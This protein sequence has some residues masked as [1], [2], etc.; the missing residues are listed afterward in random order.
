[1]TT[2]FRAGSLT[3]V[4]GERAAVAANL[5]E[6]LDYL[7]AMSGEMATLANRSGVE[8]LAGL[9]DLA[10]REAELELARHHGNADG[11]RRGD[12]DGNR[13]LIP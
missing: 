4:H 12:R 8:M 2:S 3:I 11:S 10:K 6:V 7:A 9:L 1:M 13:A 5:A